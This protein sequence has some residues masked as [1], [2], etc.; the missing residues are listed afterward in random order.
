MFNGSFERVFIDTEVRGPLYWAELI[1]DAVNRSRMSW[2]L[3]GW[4]QAERH[5]AGCEARGS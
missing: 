4:V 1:I 2:I 5:P 3:Q